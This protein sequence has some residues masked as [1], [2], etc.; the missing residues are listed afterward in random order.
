[1]GRLLTVRDSAKHTAELLK[2]SKVTHVAFVSP[3]ISWLRV[4]PNMATLWAVTLI[5]TRWVWNWK[6]SSFTANSVVR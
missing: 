5:N 6:Y 3:N 1:M 4:T 2:K